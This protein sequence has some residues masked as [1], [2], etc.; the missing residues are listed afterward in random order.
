V[1]AIRSREQM[2]TIVRCG[3]RFLG[4]EPRARS[5]C[6]VS[7][8]ASSPFASDHRSIRFV[9]SPITSISVGDR[10]L[11][12]DRNFLVAIDALR[13]QK[14]RQGVLLAG[15]CARLRTPGGL[16]EPL[17]L[18]IWR[19]AKF[20]QTLLYESIL[21]RECLFV[22]GCDSGRAHVGHRTITVSS[23]LTPTFCSGEGCCE[24]A[25]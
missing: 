10:W 5:T 23:Q 20:A 24:S 9:S 13:L 6:M 11:V 17:S 22:G 16:G 7:A 1:V 21:A 15:A 25:V 12:F 19:A 4:R 14:P 18:E 8:R 3:F 2:R